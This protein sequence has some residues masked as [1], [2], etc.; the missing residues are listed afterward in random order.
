M[1]LRKCETKGVVCPTL[2][3]LVG[4]VS[5]SDEIKADWEGMLAHQLPQLPTIDTFL[6]QLR[7]ALAWIEE[8]VAPVPTL[9]TLTLGAQEQVLE[10]PSVGVWGAR[11]P[12]EAIRFAGANRLLIEFDYS[13]KRRLVEPY[14]LRRANTGNLLFYGWELSSAQIKACNVAKIGNLRTTGR[15]F[16]PRYAVELAPGSAIPRSVS[17]AV[18][19]PR[20]SRRHAGREYYGP[21]YILRSPVCGKE[22]RRR[23]NDTTMRRHTYPGSLGRCPSRRGYLIRVA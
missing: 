4:E 1:F 14:S 23:K 9:S 16:V 20:V 18:A 2:D 21:T 11:L 5:A 10:T 6:E 12:L 3:V 17:R 7:A 8:T 19:R 22:I 13:G 15:T